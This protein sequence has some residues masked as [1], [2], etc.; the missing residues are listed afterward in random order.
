MDAL[1]IGHWLAGTDPRSIV[2]AASISN[3]RDD[4]RDF[5]R[6]LGFSDIKLGELALIV[7]ELGSNQLRHARLGRIGVRAIERGG[8]TGIEIVAA[9]RGTG[10]ADP[11]AAL[12]GRV[13]ESGSLG[14]G[15][16]SVL[17]LADEV[18]F[19]IRA[20]EGSCIW[21]R[22]FVSPVGRRREVAILGRPIS[23]ESRSGDDA[24]FSRDEKRL[25]LTLADGLGHGNDARV[26]A[27]AAVNVAR[28]APDAD[29]EA[30]CRTASAAARG[31]RGTVLLAIEIANG[32]LV[33]A[34]AGNVLA[35]VVGPNGTRAIATQSAVLGPA[36]PRFTSETREVSAHDVVIMFTDGISSRLRLDVREPF[37]HGHPLA[38]AAH[39]LHAF[40]KSNDDAMVVVAR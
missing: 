27:T 18:D 9:D 8:V 6:R 19:D 5:A 30:I 32:T 40:G 12:A 4:V 31:T 10:I 25:V 15:I 20:G 35:H 29:V 7:S 13:R 36:T 17:R 38:I 11:G 1:L 26:A 28:T 14:V 24:C 2:D 21:A 22:M 34:G 16:S 37:M 39:V 23:G 3:A 33:S